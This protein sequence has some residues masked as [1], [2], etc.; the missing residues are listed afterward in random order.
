MVISADDMGIHNKHLVPFFCG[1]CGCRL[2]WNDE[3]Y[4]DIDAIIFCEDCAKDK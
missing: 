3:S 1:S 2:G 4:S